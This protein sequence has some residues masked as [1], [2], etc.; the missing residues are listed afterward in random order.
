VPLL[1]RSLS[2]FREK[3]VEQ[4]EAVQRSRK[5]A[6]CVDSALF[7]KTNGDGVVG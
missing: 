1:D 7:K 5:S 6:G 3:C 4:I 2:A